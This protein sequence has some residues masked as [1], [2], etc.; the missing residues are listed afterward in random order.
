MKTKN[1]KVLAHIRQQFLGRK[2][3]YPM[4]GGMKESDFKKY[5]SALNDALGNRLAA[6]NQNI[7]SDGTV[8]MNK[9]GL[10]VFAAMKRMIRT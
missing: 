9:A 10:W 2:A 4:R 5:A 8:D 1:P 3:N 6:Y 7:A